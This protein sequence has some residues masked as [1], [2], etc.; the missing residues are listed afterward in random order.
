VLLMAAPVEERQ[1]RP[2][3]KDSIIWE[4][5]GPLPVWAWALML[6][7]VVL[8]YSWWR[9][10]RAA[11]TATEQT[12]GYVDELPGGQTAPPIFIVPPANPPPVN[13][14]TPVTVTV[15]PAPPGGGAPPPPMPPPTPNNPKPAAPGLFVTVAKWTRTNPPW[16]STISGIAAHYKISPWSKVWNDPR[17]ADLRARRGKPERIQPGDR[18]FVPGAK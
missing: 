12:T 2:F 11:A 5:K 18:V 7:L 16:N 8:V 6:L 1:S 3:L 9:R 17:N 15:P 14:T 10:N 13:V 4:R